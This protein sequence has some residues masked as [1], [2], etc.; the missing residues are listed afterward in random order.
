MENDLPAVREPLTSATQGEDP[1]VIVI[2]CSNTASLDAHIYHV[3]NMPSAGRVKMMLE[4]SVSTQD[5]RG[6]QALRNKA[7]SAEDLKEPENTSGAQPGETVSYD[8]SAA[9]WLDAHRLD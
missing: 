6:V 3:T 5:I 1:G 7:S 9:L 8:M 4:N 2:K